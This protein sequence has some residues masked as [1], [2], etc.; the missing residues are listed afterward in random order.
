VVVQGWEVEG[1]GEELKNNQAQNPSFHRRGQ[2]N[3]SSFF[4][5]TQLLVVSE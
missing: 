4:K 5:V 2:E 1:V 3:V